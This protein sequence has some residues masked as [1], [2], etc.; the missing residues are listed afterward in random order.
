MNLQPQRGTGQTGE[1]DCD[2]HHKDM[3]T[4]NKINVTNST[5][6]N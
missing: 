1:K 2:R 6:V 4:K 5:K 3:A